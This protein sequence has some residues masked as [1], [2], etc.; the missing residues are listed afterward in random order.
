MSNFDTI[1]YL[2]SLGHEVT[3]VRI[4][5]ES[6]YL[7]L[8]GKGRGKFVG[9]TVF[10][11]YDNQHYD[12]LVA[13]IQPYENDPETKGIYTTIQRCDPALLA[14]A[15][16]RLKQAGDNTT[17][18]DG[19]ITHFVAFPIDVDSGCASG[20]SATDAELETARGVASQIAEALQSLGIPVVTAK[21]GNGWHILIYLA[22]LLE[23]TEDT[24]HR[25]KHCGDV[26]VSLW[27][28]D[29]TVYNP[30]RVWKLY[31]TTAKKG[32]ATV[33]RPHRQAKIL[34]PTDLST[35]EHISFD[36]LEKAIL[37]LEPTEP[38]TAE[39]DT[40]S[41]SSD[42]AP[43]RRTNGKRLPP[44]DSRDDLERLAR[45][46]GAELQG[47]WQQKA[48]YEACKTYCPLC[49]RD[50]CGV[51]SYR[52]SGEC[53]YKCHTNT[54]NGANFQ[55]LYESAGYAKAPEQTKSAYKGNGDTPID[56]MSNTPQYTDDDIELDDGD[57][58]LMEFP[59]E[60]FFGVFK[61][62]REAHLD[63]VPISDAFAFAGLKHTIASILGRKIY[64]DTAPFVY[65][66]MYT[67]FIGGSS[68]AAKG[69][70][71]RQSRDLLR[72]SAPNVLTLSGLATPEGLLNQFVKPTERV[73]D[74]DGGEVTTYSGGFADGMNNEDRIMHTLEDICDNESPRVGGFFGE[75]GSILR[76]AAKM[77]A[78]GLLE[79]IMQLYDAEPDN[80]SPTK[81]NRTV[82]EYP[83][84]SMIAATDIRLIETVLQDAYIS[85]GFTNRF[86]WY[87]GKRVKKRF[88]NRNVDQK[89]WN[90]CVQE[91]GSLRNK[92]G[93]GKEQI[94][95]DITPEAYELGQS[96]TDE[97]AAYLNSETMSETMIADSLKR[98]DMHVLK[99]ALIFSV[100]R[101]EP[102]DRAIG[103]KSVELAIR[104]AEYTTHC[105]RLIFKDFATTINKQVEDKI[106]NFL[107]KNPKTTL[108]VIANRT[109]IDMQT[110]EKALDSLVRTHRV[111]RL[112]GE[113]KPQFAV[114]KSE[115]L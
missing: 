73:E 48:D 68:D 88:L 50:K 29:A 67:A 92:F 114:I 63:R 107:R 96:F 21:S 106:L 23:V 113:R 36:D 40:A 80:D 69:N 11:Y 5:R 6:P 7:Q 8:N 28:G 9:K 115:V 102:D 111:A 109:R 91:V 46:C 104:L 25:F 41:A 16:N 72:D 4:L 99:N 15:S 32:D 37:S 10:G 81:T 105:T 103:V 98:T 70:A 27:G 38:T 95:F 79:L 17:T 75:F 59:Q 93:D 56:F 76:K 22:E 13:D 108:G 101:N 60:L 35:I 42:K 34:E 45:D 66:N 55:T 14:R 3:E 100:I 77:N 31:G 57:N 39:P 18:S 24:T 89:Q 43:A 71:L 26:I 52:A 85:G 87:L 61:D 30:S 19:N 78:T 44:L 65:P 74:V 84:F 90:K 47:N 1:A 53:G 20:I 64:L 97:L 110:L 62:Y 54:C 49:H 82:A 2:K 58:V 112:K 83:T 12:T 33:D 51:I 86:E 94:A